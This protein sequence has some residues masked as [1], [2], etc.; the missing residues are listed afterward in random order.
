MN[1]SKDSRELVFPEFGYYYFSSQVM[2]RY[3]TNNPNNEDTKYGIYY[4]VRV[5]S[6]CGRKIVYSINS[7]SSITERSFKRTSPYLSDIIKMCEGGTIQIL[8]TVRESLC[9][10]Y[11]FQLSKFFSLFLIHKT[12]C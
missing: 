2:F 6:N 4:I 9:C 3:I 10:A 1:F 12:S 11:G 7:Y 5:Q 8:I